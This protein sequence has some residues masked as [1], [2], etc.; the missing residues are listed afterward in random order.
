[1]ESGK[2]GGIMR[3]ADKGVDQKSLWIDPRSQQQP[4]KDVR[5]G[6]RK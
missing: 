3:K 6:E 4:E 2:R 1:M 5:R